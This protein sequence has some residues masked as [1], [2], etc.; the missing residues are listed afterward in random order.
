MAD[1][2]AR[3][4][5]S[6]VRGDGPKETGPTGLHPGSPR[7]QTPFEQRRMKHVNGS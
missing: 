2:G 3:D 6:V 5:W 1:H 7:Y 4:W